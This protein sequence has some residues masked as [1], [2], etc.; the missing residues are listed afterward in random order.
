MMFLNRTRLVTLG[1]LVLAISLSYFLL[2]F[3]KSGKATDCPEVVETK[4]SFLQ[5]EMEELGAD[6]TVDPSDASQ[7]RSGPDS[8]DS[9]TPEKEKGKGLVELQDPVFKYPHLIQS[10]IEGEEFTFVANHLLTS[11]PENFPRGELIDWVSGQDEWVISELTPRT[12]LIRWPGTTVEDYLMAREAMEAR[13][14]DRLEFEVDNIIRA[15]FTPT[16]PFLGKQTHHAPMDSYNGW[17]FRTDASGIVVA[18]LDSGVALQHLDLAENMFLNPGEIPSNGQDDDNN[19]FIDDVSG[20]DFYEDDSLPFD[21][22]GHGTHVSGLIGA[23]GDNNQGGT[24]IAHRVQILPIRFLNENGE[25]TSSDLLRALSYM[26]TAIK[27]DVINASFGSYYRSQI[28]FSAWKSLTE[29]GAWVSAAAG[30]DGADADTLPSY[31]A[32]FELEG[33]LSVGA[34]D[35]NG[36]AA[37]FSNYGRERVDIFAPG[38]QLYSTLPGGSYGRLSGTSQAA[39]LISGAM[40]LLRAS[41]PATSAGEL[42]QRFLNRGRHLASLDSMCASG[43]RLNLGYLLDPS[44]NG[45][46]VITSQPESVTVQV[47]ETFRLSIEYATSQRPEFQWFNENGPI[48]EANKPEFIKPNAQ[49]EDASVY[50]VRISTPAGSVESIQVAVGVNVE[51]P[52]V[53]SQTTEARITQGYPLSLRVEAVGSGA[54]SFQWFQDGI[55]IQSATN[56]NFTRENPTPADAGTYHV[57]VSNGFGSA[58]SADILVTADSPD[59]LA[60]TLTG[61]GIGAVGGRIGDLY[62]RRGGREGF[63]MLSEDY[64]SWINVPQDGQNEIKVGPFLYED[65]YYYINQSGVLRRSEDLQIWETVAGDTT[66]LPTFTYAVYFFANKVFIASSN[67]FYLVDLAFRSVDFYGVPDGLDNEVSLYDNGLETLHDNGLA[68]RSEDGLTWNPLPEDTPQRIKVDVTTGTIIGRYQNGSSTHYAF[69]RPDEEWV[70]LT[71]REYDCT[72][73][74]GRIIL[75]YNQEIDLATGLTVPNSIKF[76]GDSPSYEDEYV[77]SFETS[78][79]SSLRTT[80]YFFEETLWTTLEYVNTFNNFEIENGTVVN[81]TIYLRNGSLFYRLQPDGSLEL[82]ADAGTQL[83]EFGL[84][85]ERQLYRNNIKEFF[86]LDDSGQLV[87]LIPDIDLGAAE[88]V[89]EKG[90]MFYARFAQDQIWT[91]FNMTEWEFQEGF[92]GERIEYANNTMIGLSPNGDNTTDVYRKVVGGS[93][94]QLIRDNLGGLKQILTSDTG[95]II[96]VDGVICYS[97]D[98]DAWFPKVNSYDY[99]NI[100]NREFYVVSSDTYPGT[101]MHSQNGETWSAVEQIPENF[102]TQLNDSRF[103][104]ENGRIALLDGRQFRFPPT[105]S[106]PLNYLDTVSYPM[107]LPIILSAED[108]GNVAWIDVYTDDERIESFSGSRSFI[109][110]L[111]EKPGVK[112][113]S[114]EILYED[115]WITRS[116]T[117]QVMCPIPYTELASGTANGVPLSLVGGPGVSITATNEAAYAM[118]SLSGILYRSEDAMTWEMIYD[119]TP[120]PLSKFIEVDEDNLAISNNTLGGEIAGLYKISGNENW[121]EIANPNAGLNGTYNMFALDGEL[122]LLFSNGDLYLVHQDGSTEYLRCLDVGTGQ[123]LYPFKIEVS[124]RD[125]IAHIEVDGNAFLTDD[126]VNLVSYS[127]PEGWILNPGLTYFSTDYR[128][129][130]VLADVSGQ[131]VDIIEL[132]EQGFDWVREPIEGWFIASGSGIN[133]VGNAFGE[134]YPIDFMD[135]TSATV[136]QHNEQLMFIS[137]KGEFLT[138]VAHDFIASSVHAETGETQGILKIS[139]KIENAGLMGLISGALLECQLTLNAT[140]DETQSWDIG[141]VDLDLSCMIP[142]FPTTYDFSVEVPDGVPLGDY[143]LEINLDSNGQYSEFKEDNNQAVSSPFSYNPSISLKMATVGEGEIES[144]HWGGSARQGVVVELEAVPSAGYV[145]LRWRGISVGRTPS[146]SVP[147]QRALDLEA[148]FIPNWLAANF[149]GLEVGGIGWY[150]DLEGP[151]LLLTDYY[152]WIF[153]DGLGWMH[154]SEGESAISLF[155]SPVYGWLAK[156]SSKPVYYSFEDQTW[157]I[158]NTA[159]GEFWEL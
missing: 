48:P 35:G 118:Y 103:K 51:F 145:F 92:S 157:L 80:L 17:D 93:D 1:A 45:A 150:L 28:Q 152:N 98:G 134:L 115:G 100:R 38:L 68:Y 112:N 65:F 114:V 55:R 156:P 155:W 120:S 54:L 96:R 111:M 148:H 52:E 34:S 149:P 25:G 119:G 63:L 56:N 89:D 40:C 104:L 106:L 24:G 137:S 82:V 9:S 15:Y 102:P 94:W 84:L 133:W 37:S 29:N 81:D 110:L 4:S 57:V 18:V 16:D 130:A 7:S 8:K 46:P 136:W 143:V 2:Q 72:I 125:T 105:I 123:E 140:G 50:W 127:E 87:Q 85:D 47:G 73:G 49:P 77:A 33:I 76:G 31:P 11:I 141:R 97:T 78:S 69:L 117:I 42:R 142:T 91:S 59:S 86:Y 99:V 60:W 62:F 124:T 153:L 135:L 43:S 131:P 3:T 21:D 132:S 5:P 13:F 88:V 36:Q 158:Y 44:H 109:P 6:A 144:S 30:N 126:L 14:G 83:Y 27:P 79:T 138:V 19:G 107:S 67:L 70:Y 139:L 10:K 113:L 32:S 128:Y 101:I 116:D 121:I 147:L 122:H 75:P 146:I 22:N 58:R 71:Q 95:F 129:R 53:V 41:D 154:G 26:K 20:W 66:P 74:N 108:A 151:P 23:V 39:A 90:G 159:A 12:V 64:I 61:K